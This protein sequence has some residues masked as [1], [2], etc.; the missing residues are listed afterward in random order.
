MKIGLQHPR[1]PESI[2]E[3]FSLSGKA[4]ATSGDYQKYFNHSRGTRYHHILKPKMGYPPYRHDV[5]DSGN[6]YHD[7]CGCSFHAVR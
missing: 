1:K 6:R 3:S 4:V 2:L 5:C 7:G